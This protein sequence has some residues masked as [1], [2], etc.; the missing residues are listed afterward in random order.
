MLCLNQQGTGLANQQDV[1]TPS[2]ATNKARKNAFQP[3]QK[4]ASAFSLHRQGF[5]AFDAAESRPQR[6]KMAE[7]SMKDEERYGIPQNRS[8]SSL[9]RLA[10]I[11]SPPNQLQQPHDAALLSKLRNAVDNGYP[12]Q[13]PAPYLQPPSAQSSSRQQQLIKQ[14]LL[15]EGTAVNNTK[16]QAPR[17]TAQQHP[18][19]S[20]RK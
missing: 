9:M 3:I 13:H 5:D 2:S 11:Q 8:A 7:E 12:R 19:S 1:N 17:S 18:A 20:L 16:L 6:P 14:I 4:S 10:S 15:L